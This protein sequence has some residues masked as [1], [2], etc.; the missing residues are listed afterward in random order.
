MQSL[1]ARER[2]I[3]ESARDLLHKRQR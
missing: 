3:L 2:K 1:T